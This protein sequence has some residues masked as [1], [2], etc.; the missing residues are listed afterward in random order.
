MVA[1]ALGNGRSREIVDLVRLR[2]LGPI[3]GCN[4]LY[5]SHTPAVLVATDAPI[6]QEIQALGYAK[7]HRFYT[8]K[9]LAGSGAQIVPKPYYGFSSGPI[10]IALAALD[11]HDRIYLLGFD[12]GPLP[13]EKF[14]NIYADTPHYK[15]SIAPPTYTGNW[16]QQIITVAKNF[17]NTRFLRVHGDH[18]AEIPEFD[19]IPNLSKLDIVDFLARIN[20][21]KD[22]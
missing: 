20:T 14:N 16:I 12:L 19:I 3:Y 1:F 6:S 5:R 9:P 22:L 15:P 18:T 7:S 4:A 10:A 8:R 13:G 2:D 11:G 17:P 21:S